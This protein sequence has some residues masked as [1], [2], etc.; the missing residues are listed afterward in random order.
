MLA[1]SWPLTVVQRDRPA[2]SALPC[3]P[4]I[5]GAMWPL[6]EDHC[7]GD[8]TSS[9]LCSFVLCDALHLSVRYTE[10]ARP[11]L[12]TSGRQQCEFQFGDDSGRFAHHITPHN[13]VCA[14]HGRTV[15]EGA[16]SIDNKVSMRASSNGER[17]R[18]GPTAMVIV[19]L[20]YSTGNIVLARHDPQIGAGQELFDGL[21]INVHIAQLPVPVSMTIIGGQGWPRQLSLH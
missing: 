19:E 18:Q 15:G 2:I 21:V 3:A 11:V 17:E 20:K 9:P 6:A 5:T 1:G 4:C 8:I 12:S 7:G 16:G 10:E 13:W 14:R